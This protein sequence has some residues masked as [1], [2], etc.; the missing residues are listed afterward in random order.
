MLQDVHQQ[1]IAFKIIFI[2]INNQDNV[3]HALRLVPIVNTQII[4]MVMSVQ[5][6]N[7]DL[8]YKMT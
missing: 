1:Q 8:C 6:V 3:L 7:W 2:E 5:N 4:I